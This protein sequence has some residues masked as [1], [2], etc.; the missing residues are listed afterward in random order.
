M[1]C[2]RGNIAQVS[3]PV[4]LLISGIII[5]IAVAGTFIAAFLSSGGL[6]ERLTARARMAALSGISDAMVKVTRNKEWIAIPCGELN[7]QFHYN[8]NVGG[9]DA[10]VYVCRESDIQLNTYTYT[11]TVL[12]SASNRQKKFVGKVTVDQT[13]GIVRLKSITEAP[14]S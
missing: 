9:D 12:A 1:F 3:L 11:I 2:K 8:L 6:G 7:E 10:L 14:V 13:S 4:I 5:E